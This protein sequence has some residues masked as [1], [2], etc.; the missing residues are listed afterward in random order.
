MIKKR[1]IF[2]RILSFVILVSLITF[3][4]AR[5]Q[6]SPPLMTD[7]SDVPGDGKWENNIGFAFQGNAEANTL[8]GPILDLNYGVGKHLQLKYEMSWIA[9]KS[10]PLAS[11]LDVIELGAKYK[12]SDGLDDELDYSIYPQ[13]IFAFN[14]ESGKKVEYGFKLPAAISKEFSAFKLGIQLGVER[15]GTDAHGFYGIMIGKEFDEVVA[16]MAELHG[17]FAKVHTVT[18]VGAEHEFFFNQETFVNFGASYK[19]LKT[20]DVVAAFGRKL[21]TSATPEHGGEFFGFGGL[22]FLL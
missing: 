21:N 17:A 11:G 18:Q 2:F 6:E 20:V 9:Q 10:Q 4:S 5:S 13:V 3:E 14:N 22:Q 1:I 7:D 19:I 8:E 12:F 16:I 15:L